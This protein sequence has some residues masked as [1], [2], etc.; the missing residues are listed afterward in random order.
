[1]ASS[2]QIA[3]G[4]LGPTITFTAATPTAPTGFQAP[5]HATT[6]TSA[7]Q[8]RIINDSTVTVFLGVGATSAEAITAAG[9][10]ATSIPLLP[11]T[12]EVLRFSPFAFFT[13]KSSSGAATVYITPGQGL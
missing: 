6:N 9:A 5:V 4:P 13:G 8:Y 10:I 2:S 12:D 3:F 11:G 7:G 1:M